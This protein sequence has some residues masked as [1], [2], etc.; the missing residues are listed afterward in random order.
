MS[1]NVGFGGNV[2]GAG[3]GDL[4]SEIP[5]G[6]IYKAN[7]STVQSTTISA[8]DTDYSMNVTTTFDS[9]NSNLFSSPSSGVL[10][11]DGTR[12]FRALVIANPQLYVPSTTV[13][14]KVYQNDSE[15]N[16]YQTNFGYRSNGYQGV[17][18][19][20]P[21]EISNGDTIDLY[22]GNTANTSNISLL[23]LDFYILFLGW[24][25]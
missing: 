8:A 5:R 13:Y 11:Y 24:T 14:C 16:G 6:Y 25:D 20:T 18:I 21:I 17:P 15:V 4:A 22:V 2:G 7:T 3:G 19:C 1:G 23:G 12:S 10:Q 9:G